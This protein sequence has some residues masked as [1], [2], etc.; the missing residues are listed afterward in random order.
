MV[1]DHYPNL[2]FTFLQT[3]EN[4]DSDWLYSVQS[5]MPKSSMVVRRHG[6]DSLAVPLEMEF[7]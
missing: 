3:G 6:F 4:G 5:G 1:R 2:G 7:Q